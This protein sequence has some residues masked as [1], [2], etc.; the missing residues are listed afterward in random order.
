MHLA[1]SMNGCLPDPDEPLPWTAQSHATKMS[2]APVSRWRGVRAPRLEWRVRG[3]TD[4]LRV[5]EHHHPVRPNNV[6]TAFSVTRQR[7]IDENKRPD[8]PSP[9][10]RALNSVAFDDG[11]SPCLP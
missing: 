8:D 9:D 2:C 7:S 6:P 10:G 1:D 4:V 3:S 11:P 5:L